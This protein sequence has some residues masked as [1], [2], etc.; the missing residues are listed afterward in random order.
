MMGN[1]VAELLVR[2]KA[3][4]SNM[5]SGLKTAEGA[6][7]SFGGRVGSA[8]GSLGRYGGMALAGIGAAGVAVVGTGLKIAA[9]MEQAKIGFETMLGSAEKADAFLTDLKDFAA[10]TPFE[11]PE[12]QSAASRL[13]AV[14]TATTEVIPLMTALG[15]A[16][17]GMGTGSEGI[18]RAVTALTQM[19]QKGKVTGEEMLQLAEAGIPA[20]DALAAHMGMTV[21]EVQKLVSEGKVQVDDLMSSIENRE[22]EAMGRLSGMMEKQS[23]TLAGLFSTLKDS[24]QMALADS[25]APLVDALKPVIPALSETLG[26]L[27]ATI[28]SSFGPVLAE[29]IKMFAALMPALAPILELVGGVLA[30]ALGQLTPVLPVIA[31]AIM[32]V[33][34][35]LAP[36]VPVLATVF[37]KV[38]LVAGVLIGRLATALA[39]LIE[40]LLPPLLDLFD[41]LLPSIDDL[42]PPVIA[43]V[44][45]LVELLVAV[46]PILTPITQ[47]ITLAVRLAAVLTGAVANALATVIGWVANLV[48]GIGGLVEWFAGLPKAAGN[49]FG[50]IADAIVAAF[51]GAINWVIGAWNSLDFVIDFTLPDVPL[52]P[53]L[54]GQ[55]ITTPDLIP[56]IPMLAKGGIVRRPTLALIGEAGPE[57]VVPLNAAFGMSTRRQALDLTVNVS[58]DRKR[59]Q[60][61]ADF[62]S[63]VSGY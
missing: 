19:R 62:A 33:V 61:D 31:K 24:V 41:A 28:G 12:L 58:L 15:D 23:Q 51:K 11:F 46:M 7:K 10:K 4:I 2:V 39:P 9:D 52:V 54:D 27:V 42:I 55:R 18:Q 53:G 44:E 57:A 50:A 32:N 34:A 14:G 49:A 38:G 48:S 5:M 22:G 6:T 3:D 29:L 43:I 30:E 21:P 25:A 1:T 63:R 20:W 13:V 8:M 40:A 35:A 26:K 60:R 59:F 37:A 36:I 45:A 16:T 17:S 47:L 56:D